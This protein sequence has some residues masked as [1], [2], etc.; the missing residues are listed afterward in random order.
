MQIQERKVRKTGNSIVVTLPKDF[1]EATGIKENDTV[2]IDS[3]KL[4]EAI[5]KKEI[6]DDLDKK[7]DMLASKSLLKYRESYRKLVEK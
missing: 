4:K 2:F 1:L 5:V 6:E 7:I 3:D